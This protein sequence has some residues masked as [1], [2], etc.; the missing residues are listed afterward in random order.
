MKHIPLLLSLLASSAHGQIFAD[1]STTLGDFT[2]Q[3]DEVNSP[4]TVANFIILAEGSRP[5]IDSTTGALQ[6]NTPY[7][8]GIK[9]HRVIDNFIIQAG[10]PNG[11]GTDGPGYVFPDETANGLAFDTPY[12]LAMANSGPNSNGSQ[13]FITENTPTHLNGIHTIFGSVAVAGQ[14]VIDTIHATPV[15]GSSPTTDVIINSVTIRRVGSTAEAFDEFAEELPTVSTLT[16]QFSAADGQITLDQPPGT[17]ISIE[18]SNDLVNWSGAERFL[19]SSQTALTPLEKSYLPREFYRTPSLSALV[20]WP[21][22]APAPASYHG[23]TLTFT[24]G[25]NTFVATLNAANSPSIG[26]IA[27]DANVAPITEFRQEFTNAYGASL[28]VLSD[29]FVPLRFKLGADGPDNGRMTGTA[30]TASPAP[31]SG[32]YTLT[33]P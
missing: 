8:T 19:D 20:T 30:F 23:K 11:Q 18:K 5:W 26:T 1:F 10:S 32:P 21:A 6:S 28:L 29:A 12:L 31:I 27:I 22:S 7:Y 33:T 3:L 9:F 17:S 24:V 14:S 2:V 25:S 4:K 15:S 16:R 13:F